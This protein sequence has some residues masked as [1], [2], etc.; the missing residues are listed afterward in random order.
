MM[1]RRSKV[2]TLPPALKAELE[3]L[4]ADRTHG[5]YE[6]LAAWLKEQGYEISKSSLHRYDK[7]HVQVVMDRIRASAEAARLIVQVAP[8]EADEHSAAVL[9]MVQSALFD[10]M[11][12]V[13]AAAE[14]ADPAEQVKVLSQAARA[15]AEA[16]RASIGQKRW[17]DEVRAK[18]D[19]VE[20]VARNAGKTLDAE[21]LR[22]IREGLYGG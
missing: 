17:A 7:S 21:T 5:G 14:A 4:L 8:D 13:T 9:R 19:E 1:A 11:S 2:D 3:R 12:R 10:A 22:T 6:A 16:S 20:R 18:L 15:I